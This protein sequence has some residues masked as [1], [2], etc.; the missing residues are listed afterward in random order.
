[1]QMY[2]TWQNEFRFVS[3]AISIPHDLH[4]RWLDTQNRVSDLLEFEFGVIY[5]REK[6]KFKWGSYNMEIKLSEFY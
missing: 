1:M 6:M 3:H 4:Y 2:T 5:A